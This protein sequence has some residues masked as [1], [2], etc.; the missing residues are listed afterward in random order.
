MCTVAKQTKTAKP[1][2]EVADLA[3]TKIKAFTGQ[4]TDMKHLMRDLDAS[5]SDYGDKGFIITVLKSKSFEVR[6]RLEASGISWAVL[7]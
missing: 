2:K 4:K 1:K 7:A 5:V 3:V 6:T